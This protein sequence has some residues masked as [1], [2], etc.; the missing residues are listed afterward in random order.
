MRI[1]YRLFVASLTVLFVSPVLAQ[2]MLPPHAPGEVLVGFKPNA[3]EGRR[4]AA[5]DRVGGRVIPSRGH[6]GKEASAHRLLVKKTVAEALE[7]LQND[8]SVAFVEPNYVLTHS[9]VSNDTYYTSGNL[10]GM[11]GNDNPSCGPAN[12]T[13]QFGSDAEEAWSLGY[14]GSSDVYIGVIDEGIQLSHP[15]LSANIWHNP[16]DPVDGIDNDL[17]GYIDD[18][19]GWDFYN[20]DNSVFDLADG[21]DHGTHVAGTIGARGGNSAGVV[22]VAWNVKMIPAKFIGPNGG[23]LSDAVSAL[24][25]LRDLKTRHGLRIVATSNSWGGGGYSS[26]LHTA[27]LRAAKEGILF[28]AAAGNNATDNDASPRYPCGYST[29]QGSSIE[30]AASYEAVIAV[31]AI[32]STGALASFSNYGAFSVDLGAPGV[33]VWSSVPTNS[34]ASYNGTSMATPHVSGAVALYAAAF[35]G[36]S[37]AQIRLAILSSVKPTSSLAGITATG[38]RLSLEGL[39][40]SPPPSSTPTPV[41]PT[42]TPVPP[43]ATPIAPT[44]TP[45]PSTPTPVPTSPPQLHDVAVTSL[46]IGSNVKPGRTS[47]VSIAVANQGNMSESF[48]VSLAVSGGS[49]GAPVSVTLPGGGSTTVSINW[50][51]PSARG[52]YTLTGTASVVPGESDTRDNSSTRS[53]NVR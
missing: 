34:Y 36:A 17:N 46:S 47:R 29:L 42:P 50:S 44:P 12:T 39:F 23:Y 41:P 15:D 13:N 14:T 30:S 35:P 48:T 43:T 38:G 2:P 10:W 18:V 53:V 11:Y 27:I 26:A 3:S 8:P 16:F 31:A 19:N 24:D 22:G 37:A 28:V 5:I 21:D 32:S 52:T 9:D 33:G 25:Y 4:R 6:S 51:A 20:R 40:G 7:E 45:T 49:V 1:G